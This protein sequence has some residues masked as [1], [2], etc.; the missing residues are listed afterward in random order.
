MRVKNCYVCGGKHH[1]ENCVVLWG[2]TPEGLKYFGEAKAALM[3]SKSN[4]SHLL[5]ALAPSGAIVDADNLYY[6]SPEHPLCVPCTE[7]SACHCATCFDPEA[8]I[9][10]FLHDTHEYDNQLASGTVSYH[11]ISNAIAIIEDEIADLQR[12]CESPQ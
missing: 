10:A 9:F 12:R 7:H 8:A 4:I 11:D 2:L 1:A 3:R 6:D 5:C